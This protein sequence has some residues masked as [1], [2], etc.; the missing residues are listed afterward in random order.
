MCINISKNFE[1]EKGS[2]GITIK[3]KKTSI[4]IANYAAQ[5]S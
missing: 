5:A 3:S 2:I 1:F 4:A